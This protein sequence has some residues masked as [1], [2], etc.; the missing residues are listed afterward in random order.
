MSRGSRRESAR[1]AVS[2]TDEDHTFRLNIFH[3]IRGWPDAE[4]AFLARPLAGGQFFLCYL[5]S[6]CTRAPIYFIGFERVADTTFAFVAS[7]GENVRA[8][9]KER[10]REG[11]A[12]RRTCD[13]LRAATEL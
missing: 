1:L 10:E 12:M 2:R 4:R 9:K 5:E 13:P 6:A 8:K 3:R 7:E 11:D